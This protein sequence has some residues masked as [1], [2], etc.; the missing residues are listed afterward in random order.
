MKTNKQQQR[1]DNLILAFCV[2]AFV[3][4]IFLDDIRDWVHEPT[5]VQTNE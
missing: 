3:F 4:F 5:Q 2:V 1:E